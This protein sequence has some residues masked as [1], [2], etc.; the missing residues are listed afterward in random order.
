MKTILLFLFMIVT[1]GLFSAS[2]DTCTAISFVDV[3][4]TTHSLCSED[5]ISVTVTRNGYTVVYGDGLGNQVTA[6]ALIGCIGCLDLNE[7]D[8]MQ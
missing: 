1:V 4:G 3:D 5:L 8:G 6:Y 7:G 2:S